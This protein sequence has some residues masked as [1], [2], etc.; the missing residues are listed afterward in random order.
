MLTQLLNRKAW[1][2]RRSD[3]GAED[4][5]GNQTPTETTTEIVCEVQQRSRDEASDTDVSDTQ[6]L[7]IFP[8]GTELDSGDAIVVEGLGEF[9]LDGAP[10]PA[11]NPR[12]QAESHVEATLR[13]TA[14]PGAGS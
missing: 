14:G 6:W 11:R 5:Y 10:W 4:E 13:R 8:A 1:L 2:V 9:E 12:T 3:S 7:G